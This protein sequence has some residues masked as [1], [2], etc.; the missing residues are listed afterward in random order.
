[1]ANPWPAGTQVGGYGVL[2]IAQAGYDAEASDHDATHVDV[3]QKLSVEENR[4][5]RRPSAL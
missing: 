2:V 1:M 5:T 4:P 3:L